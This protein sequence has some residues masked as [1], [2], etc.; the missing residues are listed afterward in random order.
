ME[1]SNSI[2]INNNYTK[3]LQRVKDCFTSFSSEFM[4]ASQYSLKVK[5]ALYTTRF[6]YILRVNI[7]LL[8]HL[9]V[10][11]QKQLL[12]FLNSYGQQSP[13]IFKHKAFKIAE[14][15]TFT[16]ALTQVIESLEHSSNGAYKTEEVTSEIN[17]VY[18]LIENFIQQ[19]CSIISKGNDQQEKIDKFQAL[20]IA[21]RFNIL[22]T[23]PQNLFLEHMLL[24]KELWQVDHTVNHHKESNIVLFHSNILSLLPEYEVP[25]YET[26]LKQIIKFLL[27][28]HNVLMELP[29][30]K[31][32][33]LYNRLSNISDQSPLHNKVLVK[34][35]E[36]AKLRGNDSKININGYELFKLFES[37]NTILHQ[38]ENAEFAIV[39]K[40]LLKKNSFLH[41]VLINITKHIDSIMIISLTESRDLSYILSHIRKELTQNIQNGHTISLMISSL[42]STLASTINSKMI[43]RY[44]TFDIFTKNALKNRYKLLFKNI[45]SLLKMNSNDTKFIQYIIIYKIASDYK[46]YKIHVNEASPSTRRTIEQEREEIIKQLSEINFIELFHDRYSNKITSLNFKKYARKA[47][48]KSPTAYITLIIKVLLNNFTVEQL[49]ALMKCLQD[50]N[51]VTTRSIVK[52][53]LLLQVKKRM[54]LGKILYYIFT[55]KKDEITILNHIKRALNAY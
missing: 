32:V 37:Y 34:I 20:T 52:Q 16:A 21:L 13:D 44:G 4:V 48:T 25:E 39:E 18:D 9:R 47:K 31:L 17:R 11:S 12:S 53:E 15:S 45:I 40:F 5:K 42:E 24:I 10:D 55:R 19:C 1:N 14:F 49:Q 6:I 29:N 7:D 8:N 26:V 51:L 33:S 36:E 2:I 28:E 41:E 35:Y 30:A 27:D 23:E 22:L 43:R 50:G 46:D 54:T 3:I 38:I